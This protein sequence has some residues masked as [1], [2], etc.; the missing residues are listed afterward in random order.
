MSCVI[1]PKTGQCGGAIDYDYN[2][3]TNLSEK[4]KKGTLVLKD[5]Q[6]E[7]N[8]THCNR[9]TPICGECERDFKTAVYNAKDFSMIDLLKLFLF[10][11]ML[12]DDLDITIQESNFY[13]P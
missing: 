8:N 4:T 13:Y 6:K 9:Y 7:Y 3:Y 11:R 12:L 5:L 2:R 10:Y 1:N